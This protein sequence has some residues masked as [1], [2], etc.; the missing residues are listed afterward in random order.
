MDWVVHNVIK[1]CLSVNNLLV[2]ND[3]L[4]KIIIQVLYI[5]K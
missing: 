5:L 4:Y 2:H 1:D 3:W